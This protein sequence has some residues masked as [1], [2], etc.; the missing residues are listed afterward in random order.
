MKGLKQMIVEAIEFP[1]ILNERKGLGLTQEQIK[2]LTFT[3]EDFEKYDCEM[4]IVKYGKERLKWNASYITMPN[5]RTYRI[6]TFKFGDYGQGNKHYDRAGFEKWLR[7][8]SKMDM[9]VKAVEKGS[10]W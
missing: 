5:P 6:N 2:E 10:R 8:I 9:N 1:K 4:F 3:A 7:R